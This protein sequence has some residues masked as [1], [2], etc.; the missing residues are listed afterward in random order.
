MSCG[1]PRTPV[2]GVL[3]GP[4]DTGVL[5]GPHD[6]GVL[7]GPHDTGILTGPHDTGVLGGQYDTEV[8]LPSIAKKVWQGRGH[9]IALLSF[10]TWCCI[11]W[12]GP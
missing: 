10:L 5:T 4:H 11:Y 12:R 1:P 9:M 8:L 3:T 7:G 2:S 6:T